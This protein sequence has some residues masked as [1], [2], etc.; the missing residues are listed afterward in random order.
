ML[1]ARNRDFSFGG[2]LCVHLYYFLI[3][4]FDF[5]QEGIA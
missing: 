3:K 4:I 2:L 1:N 5:K